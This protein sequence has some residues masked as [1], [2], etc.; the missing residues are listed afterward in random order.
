VQSAV[1]HGRERHG[2][3]FGHEWYEDE[4]APITC[5]T[6]HAGT[7]DPTNVG[8]VTG[9]YYLDT[10]G[11]YSWPG[12]AAPL[13]CGAC[14]TGEQ[15][16]QAARGGKVLP[17]RHVNG[18]RDVEFDRR[19]TLPSGYPGLPAGMP[20]RPYWH[21]E[22]DGIGLRDDFIA[23]L[24]VVVQHPGWATPSGAYSAVLSF[25]LKDATWDPGAKS[26]SNVPCHLAQQDRVW[27]DEPFLCAKCHGQ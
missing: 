21:Y 9:F 14:H 10:S 7:V 15:G 27:G 3:G 13:V 8:S 17:L 22:A 18:R 23:T 2:N 1:T 5:Q 24:P 11:D 4:S 25:N 6:C 19:E 12:V 20:E 16:G 26:C